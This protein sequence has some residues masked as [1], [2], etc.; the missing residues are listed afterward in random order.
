[1]AK[2][3]TQLKA[4]G[5]NFGAILDAAPTEVDRPKPWPV[6]TYLTVI[7]GL[8]EYGQSAKKK[9]EQ[10][11]FT[12]NFLQALEDVDAEELAA[13]GGIGGKSIK[14]TFYMTEASIYRLDEF[15]EH[16]FGELDPNLTRRQR[17]EACAGQQVLITIKHDPSEDGKSVF[18][19]VAGTAPVSAEDDDE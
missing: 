16:V 5:A 14:N 11:V 19:R 6:G 18:A 9:T 10:V 7:H 13:M 2:T 15:H 12:H 17:N 1:M 4:P 8:P 3:A